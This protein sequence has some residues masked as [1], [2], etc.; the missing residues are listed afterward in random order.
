MQQKQV[1]VDYTGEANK[2]L[3]EAKNSLY[4]GDIEGAKKHIDVAK[5]K[6]DNLTK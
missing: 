5:G 4:S 3:D 2:Y 6:L 1:S